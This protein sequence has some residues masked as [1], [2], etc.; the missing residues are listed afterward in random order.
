MV[1]RRERQKQI[2]F[3]NDRQEKQL[4]EQRQEQISFAE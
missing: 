1:L 2:P 4:Q 3:G